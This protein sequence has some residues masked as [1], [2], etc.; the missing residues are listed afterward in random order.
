MCTIAPIGCAFKRPKKEWE[1]E[2]SL[3]AESNRARE[4][5]P[6]AARAPSFAPRTAK[7]YLASNNLAT[8]T[9]TTYTSP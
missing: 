5:T 6:G 9:N 2:G 3:A 4:V 8:P 7:A 1:R